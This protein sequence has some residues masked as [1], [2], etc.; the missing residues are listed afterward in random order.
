METG[1]AIITAIII[2]VVI[3]PIALMQ[4]G[5]N[6]KS[7][8]LLHTLEAMA[9]QHK[10]RITD[11]DTHKNFA[12]GFDQM[13]NH[14]YFYKKTP[15]R[16]MV[17]D[18]DLN[19]IRTCEIVRQTTKARKEKQTYEVLEKLQLA[20]VPMDGKTVE[21]IELYDAQESFQ[22]SGELDI[23]TKWMALVLANKNQGQRETFDMNELVS[24][25]A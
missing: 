2:A 17:Q 9:S 18:I 22:L 10:G 13:A 20:F 11:H 14:I 12:I 4:I 19:K 15:E 21:H 6:K 25:I 24:Q 8:Q 5:T 23:A 7:K 1:I 3:V 16:E